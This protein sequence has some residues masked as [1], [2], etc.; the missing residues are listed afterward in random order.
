V[1]RRALALIV[2]GT[3]IG[4]VASWVAGRWVEPLLFEV[5]ATD[6]S[7]Y[8]LVGVVLLAVAALAGSLPAWR[9]SGVDPR[10]ALQTD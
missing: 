5:S 1:L 9:A 7:V 6:P 10:E 8:V 4:L 2:A 3:A